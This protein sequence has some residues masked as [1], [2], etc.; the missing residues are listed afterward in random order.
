MKTTQELL[1]RFSCHLIFRHFMK[2]HPATSIRICTGKFLAATLHENICVTVHL[3]S[4]K[5]NIYCSKKRKLT[6][7]LSSLHFSC[8]LKAFE[9]WLLHV[10]LKI[11]IGLLA[12]GYPIFFNC[13]SFQLHY[14]IQSGVFCI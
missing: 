9:M 12:F 3:K 1:D 6:K 8:N 4:N 7:K 13:S 10:H 5:L 14:Q 11:Y 2:N